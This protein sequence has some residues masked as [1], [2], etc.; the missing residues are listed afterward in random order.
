MIRSHHLHN[1]QRLVN[2]AIIL[3]TTNVLYDSKIMAMGMAGY[4]KG[5]LRKC[6][7]MKKCI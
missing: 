3:N 1:D 5:T 4:E 7:T 2:P 6:K